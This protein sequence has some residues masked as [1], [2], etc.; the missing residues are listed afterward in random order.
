MI[1]VLTGTGRCGTGYMAKVLHEAGINTGHE[2][3]FTPTGL[4]AA[5]VTVESSWMAVPWLHAARRRSN[6]G[7]VFRHP[8]SVIS[9]FLGIEFFEHPSPYLDFLTSR[10]PEIVG[11]EPI[12][13]ACHHYVNWN[14]AALNS[15]HFTFEIDDVPWERIMSA[16]PGLGMT[17]LAEAISSVEPTYNH[18]ERANV[19]VEAITPEVWTTY[20]LLKDAANA[21]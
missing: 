9:S 13:A 12:E 20:E 3:Y 14:L 6:I 2:A 19:D 21:S 1:L 4:S 17:D 18:R 15:A 11:M 8:A 16:V 10:L 5:D 7:L